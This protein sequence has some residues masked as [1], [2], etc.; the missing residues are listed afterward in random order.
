MTTLTIQRAGPGITVQDL[1]RPGFIAQGLSRGGAAD[2]T[3]LFEGAALLSQPVTAALELPPVPLTL[4]ADAPC[5][6][7]LTGAPMR[8]ARGDEPLAWAASHQLT[9]EDRLTLSPQGGGFAYVSFGGGIATAPLMG[10]RAAHLTAGIGAPLQD[11]DTLPLGD[12]TGKVTNR[13]LDPDPR[14]TDRPLRLLPSAHTQLFDADTLARFTDTAFT[15]DT[16]GNRQ[17]IRL[18]H[19]GAP[20]ATDGQLSLLSEI[21]RPGDIQMTGEGTPYILGPECQTTGG[22]PR[23]GA[24]IP[25]DLSRAMQAAPGTTLRFA[26]VDRADAPFETGDALL[27]RLAKRVRPLTRDPRDMDLSR[28]QLISGMTTGESE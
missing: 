19:D 12:D 28:Y 11:G 2:R 10:S 3:A 17:G 1:G 6:I 15:R 22:Y 9:P 27:A 21:A 14:G 4:T 8:A 18:R 26:F 5:R 24:I 16:R 23:I 13:T 7:A 20:F 25:A